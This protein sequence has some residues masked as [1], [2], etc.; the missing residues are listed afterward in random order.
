MTNEGYNEHAHI[1]PDGKYIVWMSSVGNGDTFDY[2]KVGTDYWLMNIDGSNKQ[3]LTY[4]NK[5]D[6]PHFRG[7]YAVAADFAWDPSSSAKNG[8][9]MFA[10]LHELVTKNFGIRVTDRA[11][12][13]EYNFIV[14]FAIN[15]IDEQETTGE[16]LDPGRL[17]EERGNDALAVPVYSQFKTADIGGG[18][19]ASSG[20][21][22]TSLG[23]YAEDPV[24]NPEDPVTCPEMSGA[25]GYTWTVAQLDCLASTGSL[26]SCSHWYAFSSQKKVSLHQGTTT[27]EFRPGAE[28]VVGC[29]GY[30]AAGSSLDIATGTFMLD[31]Q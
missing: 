12:R 30:N 23:Y 22:G 19:G 24:N 1:S 3:R 25:S 28:Y 31:G 26:S 18:G 11:A 7:R 16:S 17:T 4:L 2:Y 21:P 13:G 27:K 9:R 5:P 20:D 10:Y 29:I 6:H 15:A 14:E 8:Y